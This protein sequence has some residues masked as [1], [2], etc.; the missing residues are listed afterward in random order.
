MVVKLT[1]GQTLADVMNRIGG[2][3][4]ER[5]RV[6]PPLGTATV[7]DV[8]RIQEKEG[9]LCELV[10]GV[11]V[12]KT[13]GLQESSLAVFLAGMLNLFVIPRN[14]G[15]VTGADGTIQLVRDLVRI[16]DVAFFSW[17]RLP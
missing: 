7:A 14:L 17:D 5:V 15:K 9:R 4:P 2:V 16:P 8:T 1:Q 11:L 10:E 13:M 3:P 12:E 6:H